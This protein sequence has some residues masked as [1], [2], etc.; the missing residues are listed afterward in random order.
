MFKTETD[1]MCWEM[2]CVGAGVMGTILA[3]T[4]GTAMPQYLR[5]EAVLIP[6]GLLFLMLT[7]PSAESRA[8]AE[9]ERR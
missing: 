3:L 6:L 5:F 7:Q 8:S 4:M 1:K 9:S 2:F